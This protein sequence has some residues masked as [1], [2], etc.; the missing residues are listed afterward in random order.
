MALL[1]VMSRLCVGRK[2]TFIIAE[3][4]SI[5]SLRYDIIGHNRD[6]PSTTGSVYYKGR[7]S[8]SGGVP[9]EVFYDL[10]T[11]RYG[12][13]EVPNTTRQVTY[14]DVVGAYTNLY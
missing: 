1:F 14:I 11:L 4:H 8:V 2:Y 7:N 13:T 10:N 5:R 9:T 12:S 6:L 3:Y